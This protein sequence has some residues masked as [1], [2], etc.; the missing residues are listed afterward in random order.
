MQRKQIRAN[1]SNW[2]YGIVS[3]PGSRWLGS[4]LALK[5]GWG[6]K[7]GWRVELQ[8]MPENIL[9]HFSIHATESHTLYT[10][11]CISNVQ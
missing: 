9:V 2:L 5:L 4:D 10:V 3:L 6:K 1:A 7:L 8:H 11:L